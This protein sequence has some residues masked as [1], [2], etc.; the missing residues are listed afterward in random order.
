[1]PPCPAPKHGLSLYLS[2]REAEAGAT[3]LETNKQ[4]K[5]AMILASY[6]WKEGSES[7]P[8]LW[9]Q[10]CFKPLSYKTCSQ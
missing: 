4:K 1:M 6:G 8:A 10:G 2:T 9:K 5:T 3:I 7:L